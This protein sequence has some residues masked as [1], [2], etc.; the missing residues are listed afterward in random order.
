MAHTKPLEAASLSRN[1]H[2]LLTAPFLLHTGKMLSEEAEGFSNL[3]IP[4][5]AFVG[6]N[7]GFYGDTLGLGVLKATKL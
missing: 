7:L 5:K 6:F 3:L 2:C 1:L 4:F